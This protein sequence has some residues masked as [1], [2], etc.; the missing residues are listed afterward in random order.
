MTTAY[1]AT[2]IDLHTDSEVPNLR[3]EWTR[4]AHEMGFAAVYDPASAWDIGPEATPTDSLQQVNLAALQ[5]CDAL[6]AILPSGVPTLG[7]PLEIH[8]ATS[9]GKPTLVVGVDKPSWTLAWFAR[10]G[11]LFFENDLGGFVQAV[12]GGLPDEPSEWDERLQA[13]KAKKDTKKEME[14]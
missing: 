13:W 11:S 1:L 4:I 9:M 14:L 3:K 12:A 8:M 5:A 7:V 10:S 2:P 6:I